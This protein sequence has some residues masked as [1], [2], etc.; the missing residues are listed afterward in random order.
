[1]ETNVTNRK[2]Y[3]EE[4]IAALFAAGTVVLNVTYYKKSGKW[5][6]EGLVEMPNTCHIWDDDFLIKLDKNQ[7]IIGKGAY[8][9]FYVSV[10]DSIYREEPNY[11]LFYNC[12]FHPTE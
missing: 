1:M 3:T 4:E 9:G 6:S 7:S 12:L 2:T 5:Y 8:R 11:R 10:S